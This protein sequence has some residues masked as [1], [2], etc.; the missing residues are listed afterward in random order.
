MWLD[1]CVVDLLDGWIVLWLNSFVFGRLYDRADVWLDGN[2]RCFS[3]SVCQSGSHV[4]DV[5]IH[6]REVTL[7]RR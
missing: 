5:I 2:L 4:D 1:S 7:L 3:L 6:E